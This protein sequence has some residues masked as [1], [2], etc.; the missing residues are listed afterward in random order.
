MLLPVS[1][2]KPTCGA[3]SLLHVALEP[4]IASRQADPVL[5][6]ED[7]SELMGG[8]VGTVSPNSDVVIA[9]EGPAGLF[10]G[11]AQSVYAGAGRRREG[12]KEVG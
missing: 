5:G 9:P 4:G 10:F 8:D 6:G 12:L 7:L 1:S 2:A 11:D 3:D